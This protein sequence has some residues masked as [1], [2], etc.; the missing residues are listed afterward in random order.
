M[1]SNP[2]PD[3]DKP[4]V[5]SAPR[6]YLS[7]D[8]VHHLAEAAG[9][10]RVP[11][12]VLAY[13][14]LRWAE[15]SGLRIGDFDPLRRRLMVE[16]TAVELENGSIELREPKDYERRSVPVPGFLVEAIALELASRSDTGRERLLFPSPE[17]AYLRNRNARRAW[18]DPAAAEIGGCCSPCT[19]CGT[20]PRAWRSAP[21]RRCS[22]CPGCSVTPARRSPSTPMPTCSTATGRGRRTARQAGQNRGR[23]RPSDGL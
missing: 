22:P 21:A 1:V 4:R 9:R 6:R 7:A 3:V 20:L 19:P 13:C 14:G 12:L 8:Q 23:I 2:I 18:F 5:R 17:G 15:L 16:Q 11:I 10:G